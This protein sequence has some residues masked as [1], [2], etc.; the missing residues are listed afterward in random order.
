[1]EVYGVIIIFIS[2]KTFSQDRMWR[3]NRNTA[4]HV[5]CGTNADS[6]NGIDLNRN[7]NFLWMSKYKKY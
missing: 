2:Y 4:N 3:K 7:F 5:M 1:M 6:G